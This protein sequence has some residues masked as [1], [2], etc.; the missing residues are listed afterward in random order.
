MTPYM[1]RLGLA[2]VLILSLRASVLDGHPWLSSESEND[3]LRERI[4]PP[5]GFARVKADSGS[6]GH[7]LRSLP[8]KPPG[9]PIY[10]HNGSRK[11]DQSVGVAVID[12]D[13]GEKDLQ[14]C[15]DAVM[16]LRAEYLLAV[17]HED[18]IAFNYTSGDRA[19]Y[20]EWKKGLRARV[21]GNR[22]TWVNSAR[23]DSS[24]ASFREYLDSVFMYAGTFSL[25][26]ELKSKANWSDINPGDV[27]IQG[28][29][30]GHAVIVVDVVLKVVT[31]ERM[32]LLAQGFTPA[33]DIHI[34]SN[35]SS[36]GLSPWYSCEFSDSLKTPQWTFTKAALKSF[37]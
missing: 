18:K 31:G 1:K 13:T 30:P 34:L 6:F 12:I 11:Y 4:S 35:P 7:W 2:L 17:G 26:Q 14:Q 21:K 5:E 29:F 24:Y 25:S 36:P 8:L 27:I 32:F 15:A 23:P 19:K 10:L 22:V 16:R 20:S 9:T 33:Q 3:T 37:E 28:G